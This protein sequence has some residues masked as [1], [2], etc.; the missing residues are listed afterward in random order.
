[1]LGGSILED[2]M[3]ERGE[4]ENCYDKLKYQV[5]HNIY[6]LREMRDSLDRTVPENLIKVDC[7]NDEIRR[8][9]QLEFLYGE[10]ALGKRIVRWELLLVGL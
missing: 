9:K 8:L 5:K 4:M 3:Y 2:L 10:N 7:L 1:M 6:K